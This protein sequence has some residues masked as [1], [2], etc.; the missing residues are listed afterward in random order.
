MKVTI[1]FSQVIL[2]I[3]VLSCTDNACNENIKNYYYPISETPIVYQ[4]EM[5]YYGDKSPYFEMLKFSINGNDTSLTKEIYRNNFKLFITQEFSVTN[6]GVFLKKNTLHENQLA[7][8]IQINSDII[9][10][11]VL[12]WKTTSK[13]Y[14]LKYSLN[15]RYLLRTRNYAGQ[16][17]EIKF[18]GVNLKIVSFQDELQ[19]LSDSENLRKS[20]CKI[21]YGQKI[22]KIIKEIKFPNG[23]TWRIELKNTL[24]INEFNKLKKAHANIKK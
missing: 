9:A 5:S 1:L 23:N 12:L 14:S 19:Q 20:I 15:E 2:T 21:I 13:N 16:S 8:A 4:Y 24:T 11:T 6:K 18:N 22:G 17:Q 7:N 3:I 10:D